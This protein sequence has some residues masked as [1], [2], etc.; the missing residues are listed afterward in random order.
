MIAIR[1]WDKNPLAR[2]HIFPIFIIAL[3]GKVTYVCVK[4]NTVAYL[5]LLLNVLFSGELS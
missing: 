1:R 2:L 5:R 4:Q 3:N